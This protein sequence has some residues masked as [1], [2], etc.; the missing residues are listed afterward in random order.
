LYVGE[1][2]ARSGEYGA[3]RPDLAVSSPS[4]GIS[5]E[6]NEADDADENEDSAGATAVKEA[7]SPDIEFAASAVGGSEMV[8]PE[9][10][11]RR[12]AIADATVEQRTF[13]RDNRGKARTS[14][15]SEDKRFW[16]YTSHNRSDRHSRQVGK[17]N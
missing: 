4:G 2:E 9:C 6:E 3:G 12:Y 10:V 13:G 11:S 17:Q 15:A 8:Y 1:R 7:T 5:L 16:K 14:M